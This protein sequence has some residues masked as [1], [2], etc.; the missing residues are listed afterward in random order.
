MVI[1]VKDIDVAVVISDKEQLAVRII[2]YLPDIII[3]KQI[4]LTQC[5]CYLCGLFI[6]VKTAGVQ[7]IN[8]VASIN[9]ILDAGCQIVVMD[10]PCACNHTR[11][12][13]NHEHHDEQ[14]FFIH[15]IHIFMGLRTYILIINKLC[16]NLSHSPLIQM[17]KIYIINEKNDFFSLIW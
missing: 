12:C 4:L 3:R 13:H 16:N 1:S 14:I 6:L 10:S 11:E 8:P 9:D 17:P 2:K 7:I 5:C 15:I